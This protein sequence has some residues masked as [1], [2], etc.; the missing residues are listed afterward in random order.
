MAASHSSPTHAV[1][2]NPCF[3]SHTYTNNN[4]YLLPKQSTYT[5]PGGQSF[6]VTHDIPLISSS[7]SVIKG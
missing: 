3:L 7:C 4:V 2:F 5:S 1:W 6:N